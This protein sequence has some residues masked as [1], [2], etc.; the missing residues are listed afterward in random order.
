MDTKSISNQE[1]RLL[2]KHI[3]PLKS[4]NWEAISEFL[5]G[6]GFSKSAKQCKDR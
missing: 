1:D 5:K 4:Q 6:N 2:K 3:T